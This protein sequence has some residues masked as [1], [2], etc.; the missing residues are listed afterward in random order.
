MLLLKLQN[1][2]AKEQQ[3]QAALR[4]K[5]K[6]EPRVTGGRQG[7][8]CYGTRRAEQVPRYKPGS[9]NS[10]VVTRQICSD[11]AGLRSSWE[12][13]SARQHQSQQRT[14]PGTAHPWG[15]LG[16]DLG[17][18]ATPKTWGRGHRQGLWQ[19]T[20]WSKVSQLHGVGA[21]REHVQPNA[22]SCKTRYCTRMPEIMLGRSALIWKVASYQSVKSIRL[23][24]SVICSLILKT[25][26]CLFLNLPPKNS[27]NE[28]TWSWTTKQDSIYPLF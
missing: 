4:G 9:S 20:V 1:L 8:Q 27:C 5:V 24:W 14:W 10:P 3:G 28:L 11:E 17:L 21:G 16:K 7:P 23:D 22:G 12:A 6:W 13:K 15:S 19:L 26:F 25:D 18:S 2:T